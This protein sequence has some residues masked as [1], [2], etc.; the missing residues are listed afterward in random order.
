MSESTPDFGLPEIQ[1]SQAQPEVTHN[2]AI[3]LLQSLHNG[4]IDRTNTPPGSPAEGDA[5]LTQGA[6]TG[7]W[8][9]WPNRVAIYYGGSWRFLPGADDAGSAITM[10][11]RQEGL[12]VYVRDEDLMYRWTGSAWVAAS[13]LD[14]TPVASLASAATTDI[15]AQDSSYL[16]ITGSTTIT[17]LGTA[18]RSG[19][20]RLLRF[21]AALVLTYNATTLILPGSDDFLTA[22]GDILEFV[23]E[24]S[25]WRCIRALR[26]SGSA[27]NFETGSWTPVI[28]FAT[29]GTLAV[30]HTSQLGRYTREGRMALV[31]FSVT[32]API[33]KGTASGDFWVTG[34]PFAAAAATGS[35]GGGVLRFTSAALTFP[36]G[37]TWMSCFLGAG[38]DYLTFP[39]S[40]SAVVTANITAA[41]FPASD[42][43]TFAG[44]MTHPID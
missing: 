27:A 29:P 10:G 9:G 14:N 8:T 22:A 33:T 18:S 20:R 36:T 7:A 31:T 2:E 26:R 13:D 1:G 28:S 41:D 19:I 3:V 32:G 24:G 34:L 37:K 30:T 25:N 38:L 5:Y 43:M 15:G 11:A 17:S 44:T 6:P 35:G 16:N 39:A 42:N 12:R 21:D 4:V 23:S 40:G